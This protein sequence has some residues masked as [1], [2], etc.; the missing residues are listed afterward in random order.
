MANLS[1]AKCRRLALSWSSEI[2]EQ[3]R[4]IDRH[5]LRTVHQSPGLIT[6]RRYLT[7]SIDYAG[8]HLAWT[9]CVT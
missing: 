2:P 3:A 8:G 7:L 5:L 9:R 4:E 1:L 6:P